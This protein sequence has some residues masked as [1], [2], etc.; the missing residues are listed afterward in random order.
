MLRHVGIGAREQQAVVGAVRVLVQTFW[1]L[2][3]QRLPCIGARHGAG[4]VGA[5]DPAR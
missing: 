5:A 4:E 3:T 1:P 2:I